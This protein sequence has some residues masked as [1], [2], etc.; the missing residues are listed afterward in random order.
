MLSLGPISIQE[1]RC[2]NC[3]YD[4]RGLP[5]R[6]ICPECGKAYDGSV[7]IVRPRPWKF[8]GVP[9]TGA[10]IAVYGIYAGFFNPSVMAEGN[11]SAAILVARITALFMVAPFG[12]VMLG[13]SIRYWHQREQL[14]IS[15][16]GIRWSTRVSPSQF[17]SW[18][19]VRDIELM[20]GPERVKLRIHGGPDLIIPRVF[21][22]S[23]GTRRLFDFV[24]KKWREY[25]D[26]CVTNRGS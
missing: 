19:L 21:C 10:A 17:V 23:V 11:T 13:Y 25:G 2:P 24:C 8:Y 22:A 1:C 18:Y 7:A 12:L 3:G 9:L 6:H 4:L 26:H 15:K 20:S 16:D 14:A 5:E